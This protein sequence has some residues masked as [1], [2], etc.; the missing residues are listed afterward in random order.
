MLII[1]N[2]S[3]SVLTND[4]INYYSCVYPVH[5]HEYSRQIMTSARK[6]S[7]I[8]YGFTGPILKSIQ[9]LKNKWTSIQM[10]NGLK[11]RKIKEKCLVGIFCTG[12]E[13]QIVLEKYLILTFICLLQFWSVI[14]SN[15][16]SIAYHSQVFKF[17]DLSGIFSFAGE[18]DGLKSFDL[19]SIMFP[20]WTPVI[21]F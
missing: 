14:H 2:A 1:D 4:K 11:W 3:F 7:N 20:L 9:T 18:I 19:P 12:S 13:N 15:F 6:S 17:I 8:N 16:S 10:V 5:V 21:H